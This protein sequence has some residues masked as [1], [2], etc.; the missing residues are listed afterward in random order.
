MQI[1]A[2]SKELAFIRGVTTHVP[3]VDRKRGDVFYPKIP[4]LNP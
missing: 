3:W 4:Y 2:G 1:N